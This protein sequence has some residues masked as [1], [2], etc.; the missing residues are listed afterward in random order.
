MS[1]KLTTATGT[2][3]GDNQNSLTAGKRG[4]TL[5]QDTW[6]LEKLAHFDR[7]RIPERVVHAKGSAAYGELTITND[8]TQ[9]SKADIF[10]QIGK[11]TKAFLRF[12]TWQASGAQQMR[13]AMC[14]ALRSNSTQ[15]R[16]IGILSAT[17]RLCFSLKTR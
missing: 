5:L 12:S 16:E 7:E 1:K 15:M 6:L 8:I 13:S 11:K 9:Y 17:T 14:E 4:P 10:S 3:I 2:P